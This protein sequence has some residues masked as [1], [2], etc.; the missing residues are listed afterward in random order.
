MFH[1]LLSTFIKNIFD[2][3]SR[4][5]KLNLFN[6]STTKK[7]FCIIQQFNI[8]VT[9]KWFSIKNI[10]LTCFMKMWWLIMANWCFQKFI[11]SGMAFRWSDTPQCRAAPATLYLNHPKILNYTVYTCFIHII[12]SLLLWLSLHNL[13]HNTKCL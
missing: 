2:I 3:S 1:E 11:S 9:R 6:F 7:W 10:D 8:R 4:F 13:F 12:A 5:L